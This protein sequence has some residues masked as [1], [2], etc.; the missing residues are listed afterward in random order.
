MLP[1][2]KCGK[3][4]AGDIGIETRIMSQFAKRWIFT[5]VPKNHDNNNNR[6]ENQS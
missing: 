2:Q 6:T 1:I 5:I 3:K 4:F